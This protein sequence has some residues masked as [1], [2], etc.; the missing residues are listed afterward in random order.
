M[1]RLLPVQG[2]LGELA[3][4]HPAP[5]GQNRSM[6]LLAPHAAKAPVLPIIRQ[7]L[8]ADALDLDRC[9]AAPRVC[10]RMMHKS[11]LIRKVGAL[12]VQ[13]PCCVNY[14]SDITTAP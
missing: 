14:V 1:H 6:A 9:H 3:D 7:A 12:A 5:E 2:Q 11:R 10:T 13:R 4:S 8:G